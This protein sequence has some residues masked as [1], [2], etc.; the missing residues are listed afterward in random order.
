V[1]YR[2]D[3]ADAGRRALKNAC[4]AYLLEL[5]T[6]AERARALAQFRAADN[7]TD[8]FAALA[9]LAQSDCTERETA[10]AEFYERWQH[11]ALV[12]DKWLTVQAASRLTGTLDEVRRLTAHPA[13]ELGNPNKVYALLRTFGANLARFNAADGAGYAF[14]AERVIELN[15]RNPQVASRLARCFDRWKKFDATRQAHARAAL[16]SIRDHAGLSRD[17]LEIVSRALA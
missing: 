1:P 14:L 7:M 10:L 16:E 8:Q 2:P 15:S 5:D 13:F 9:C 3:A 17:V 12:V 6:P 11:E 4:L